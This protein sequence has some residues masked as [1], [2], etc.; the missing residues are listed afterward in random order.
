MLASCSQLMLNFSAPHLAWNSAARAWSS[1]EKP[2]AGCVARSIRRGRLPRC[3]SF[4]SMQGR[5]NFPFFE[6]EREAKAPRHNRMRSEA[7]GSLHSGEDNDEDHSVF[8]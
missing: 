1:G 4:F 7:G 2:L 8:G 3:Y 6:P 5:M